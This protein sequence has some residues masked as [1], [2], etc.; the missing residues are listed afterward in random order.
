MRRPDSQVQSIVG[1]I[2]NGRL[3]LHE[4]ILAIMN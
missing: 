3:K 2:D 4:A 1:P